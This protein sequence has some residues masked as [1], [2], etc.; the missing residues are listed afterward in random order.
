MLA[1]YNQDLEQLIDTKQWITPSNMTFEQA[2]SLSLDIVTS[3]N[4]VARRL[5]K[6]SRKRK[7]AAKNGWSPT[8]VSLIT[9]TALVNTALHHLRGTHGHSW[10][11]HESIQR[12]LVAL[13]EQWHNENQRLAQHSPQFNVQQVHDS[14]R[15]TPDSWSQRARSLPTF[16]PYLQSKLQLAR[17]QLHYRKRKEL[18]SQLRQVYQRIENALEEKKLGPIIKK[19]CPQLLFPK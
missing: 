12:G 11:D 19:F 15:D 7:P 1:K 17:S 14:I 5:N 10:L 16:I 9:Y 13:A 18:R 8:A 4:R 3:M 2:E 6:R